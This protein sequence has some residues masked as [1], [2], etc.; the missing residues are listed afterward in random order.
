MQL[1]TRRRT[2]GLTLGLGCVLLAGG[3]TRSQEQPAPP[4]EPTFRTGVSLVRVDV[5][6]T[7]RGDVPIDDLQATDFEIR[8]D[9]VPHAIESFQFVRLAGELNPDDDLSLTIRS[10]DHGAAE[11]ARD[12]V[13]LFAVFLD[14]YHVSRD[15]GTTQRIRKALAD[16]TTATM[17]PTDVFVVMDPLTPLSAL[18][19]TRSREDLLRR[20]RAFEGRRG[21][22]VPPRS[23]LEEAQL[24]SRNVRRVRAEVTL[25]ALTALVT[26][27]GA[28]RER[29]SSVVFVSE[30]PP[31]WFNDG[32][33]ESRMREVLQA[34]NRFN[35]TI[36]VVDP[37]GLATGTASDTLWRLSQETGGRAIVNTNDL[38]RGLAQVAQD[39]SAYYLLGYAPSS[40]RAEGKFR[41]I[42]VKVTRPGVRVLARKGYWEATAA[43]L[44]PTP[45]P[46]IAPEVSSAVAV[47]SQLEG[48]RQ[49]VTWLGFAPG[50]DGMTH[51]SLTWQPLAGP[52]D[53]PE[54]AALRV[55]ARQP[56]D[57]VIVDE[58]VTL[59]PDA[60][61]G[62]PPGRLEFDAQ[63]GALL[64]ELSLEASPD[65]VIDRW[66]EKI[67]VP[68]Y[69]GDETAL[70]TPRL[71]LARSAAE[72]RAIVAAP[73]ATPPTPLR[74]FRRTHR[75]TVQ[76][77][78]H[79]APDGPVS[80][81]LLN[82]TGQPLVTLP[83][84]LGADRL[85]SLELPVGSLAAG[86]Y[87]L[88]IEAK[89]GADAIAQHVAFRIV[90]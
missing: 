79:G 37:R 32:D 58:R 86:E 1:T 21:Y 29:R 57:R 46:V 34:A 83:M 15:P 9:D 75:V 90:P 11:A 69:P 8:E 38:S 41:R 85:A 89:R 74:E 36:H 67:D 51:V 14:D 6:A 76:V 78:V 7:G 72:L 82:R 49:A 3:L 30:G 62:R 31:V 12:D 18:E 55:S 33:L 80:A 54:P 10:A 70:G 25:S 64:L 88:K 26:R 4:P 23:I 73:A 81:V 45:A 50:P 84:A 13:R 65:E 61:G 39:A 44:M 68:D 22:Y 77:P 71:L 56:A 19:F 42:E 59:A 24:Q 66:T 28:L 52:A 43:E 2:V 5:T 17:K 53:G 20:F 35:V 48:H 40:S 87:V 27:L 60:G 47:F 16:W 63:P